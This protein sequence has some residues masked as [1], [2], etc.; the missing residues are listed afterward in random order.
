MESNEI[1]FRNYCIVVLGNV[2]GVL[3]EIEQISEIKPNTV[4]HGGLMIATFISIMQPKELKWH[5]INNNRNFL[6]FD[7]D[8]DNS[9]YNII[10]ENLHEGL[11]GFINKNNVSDMASNFTKDIESPPIKKNKVTPIK[12][13][14]QQQLE[15]ALKEE[16]YEEAAKLRD[17]INQG[18]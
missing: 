4:D 2:K 1:K 10:K 12:I 13:S 18:L 7:L 5:F 17:L 11:F 14:L 16:K 6:L 15:N 9:A 8:E 3:S